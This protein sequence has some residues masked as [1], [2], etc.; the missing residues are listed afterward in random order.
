LHRGAVR[1]AYPGYESESNTGS[2]FRRD[3][4][5]GGSVRRVPERCG[6]GSRP[7]PGWRL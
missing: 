4:G 3:D 5:V 7:S 6:P 1:F 2:S